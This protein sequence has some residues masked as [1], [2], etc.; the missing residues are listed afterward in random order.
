MFSCL[1]SWFNYKKYPKL[2]VVILNKSRKK[3][4]YFTFTSS[5]NDYVI[6]RMS[7]VQMKMWEWR[8]ILTL[9]ISILNWLIENIYIRREVY[10]NTILYYI[11]HT[12]SFFY[13]TRCCYWRNNCHELYWMNRMNPINKQGRHIRDL[14]KRRK[15]KC[16][17]GLAIVVTSIGSDPI[18]SE[19]EREF[20][21]PTT[22]F[23]NSSLHRSG[24]NI[25]IHQNRV[26]K[27]YY[28]PRSATNLA[29]W[30]SEILRTKFST[31]YDG[32]FEM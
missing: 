24:E 23:Q 30:P 19:V 15:S 22:N 26:L 18:R 13:G 12:F 32:Y 14:N 31:K 20:L 7:E 29:I 9:H 6:L 25:I 16:V 2:L 10:N 8:C 3:E 11:L 27:S 1:K 4:I 17:V 21:V 28:T 5:V